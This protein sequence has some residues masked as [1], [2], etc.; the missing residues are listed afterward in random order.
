MSAP[1]RRHVLCTQ[2]SIAHVGTAVYVE[3]CA[4]GNGMHSNDVQDAF[5][6]ASTEKKKRG[7]GV[8]R[9]AN[10]PHPPLAWAEP[11]NRL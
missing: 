3:L 5:Q 7:V 6:P 4:I 2:N 1:A 9:S 11:K 8:V 10:H